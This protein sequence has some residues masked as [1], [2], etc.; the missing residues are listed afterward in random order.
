MVVERAYGLGVSGNWGADLAAKDYLIEGT[1]KIIGT[2]EASA[3]AFILGFL[4]R[5]AV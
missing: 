4:P 2:V 1:K 3:F 5:E